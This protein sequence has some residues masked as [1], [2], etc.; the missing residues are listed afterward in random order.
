MNDNTRQEPTLVLGGTGKIGRRV[1]ERLTARGLPVRIGSRSGE[2]RF[3]WEDRSTWGPVLEGV[4][5][6]YVSHYWD[7]IPGAAET[8]G[9]FA[10]L[11]VE[12]GVP[13]LVLLSGRGE[14][15]AE[16]GAQAVRDSGAE[17]T[18]LHSTWFAQNFS[19]DYWREYVQ[20]RR[21]C[22]SGRRHV[23]AVRRRR[24]HR[25]RRGR[26]ADRRSAHRRGLRAHRAPAA[27]VRGGGPGNLP[28]GGPRDPL[29]TDLDRGVRR[30]RW[31]A[32]R[33]GRGRRGADLHL[34]RGARRSQ[35]PP[36]RR[37]SARP[38]P[39]A[40]GLQRLRTRRGRHRHLERR[41]QPGRMT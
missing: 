4:G 36:G 35:R 5:S 2:P 28:G 37:R 15:E 11:A 22:A 8:L 25:R 21:G 26:G 38:R 27:H 20:S 23:R 12:S 10:E 13:R 40:A 39:R 6:A 19:E 33:S 24:R 29:R 32:G 3:D 7:A 9:S 41:D 1:V 18:V 17:L 16:R 31:R 14:E 34:R 30:R